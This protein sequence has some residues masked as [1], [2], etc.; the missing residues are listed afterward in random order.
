M[1]GEELSDVSLGDDS[2]GGEELGGEQWGDEQ[3]GSSRWVL[4]HVHFR[5]F[6]ELA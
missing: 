6:G 2:L 3:L 5:P 1:D 4:N